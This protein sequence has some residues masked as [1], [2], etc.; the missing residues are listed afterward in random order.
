[1][2]TQHDQL[3]ERGERI[4]QYLLDGESICPFSEYAEKNNK[5]TYVEVDEHNPQPGIFEGMQQYKKTGEDAV[6]ALIMPRDFEKRSEVRDAVWKMYTELF[7]AAERINTP[8][9]KLLDLRRDIPPAMEEFKDPQCDRHP[10]YPID[11]QPN[12]T[13]VTSPHYRG[14]E[15]GNRHPRWSPHLAIWSTRLKDILRVTQTYPA[16]VNQIREKMAGGFGGVVYD[17][18][19]FL[20]NEKPTALDRQRAK[21]S[22]GGIVLV[23]ERVLA[24][25][26][27]QLK[28]KFG[29][30]TH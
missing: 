24:E 5:V 16:V 15:T 12:F 19:E 17:A 6:L 25:E 4:R 1:M 10:L 2:E 14:S 18:D 23:D 29:K 22:K 13:I 26:M 8:E 27:D 11:G 9:A 21:M 3:S 7:I 28:L 30:P 20:L